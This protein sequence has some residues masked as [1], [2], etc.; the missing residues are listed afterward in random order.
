MWST[1]KLKTKIIKKR[2]ITCHCN[3]CVKKKWSRYQKKTNPKVKLVFITV[4]FVTLVVS[5]YETK[6]NQDRWIFTNEPIAT[7]IEKPAE[8]SSTPSQVVDS[9]NPGNNGSVVTVK[10]NTR[11][12]THS[13]QVEVIK[14]VAEKEGIDWK[15][16][17]ALHQ[18]ETQWNCNREG[19]KQFIKPSWGCY[20]INKHYHPEVTWEQATSL[21]WSS[22]WTAKR[23]KAKAEKYGWDNAIAMHN[24]NPNNP[25]VQ[26]YLKDV[27]KIIQSL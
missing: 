11:G 20:Q 6:W 23:L 18:K 27:K 10:T 26:A 2:L 19:D 1:I 24:G 12:N 4:M 17:A 16:L 9:K 7:L 14:T 8:S 25:A 13:P 5:V 21:E 15:V 22:H 3:A